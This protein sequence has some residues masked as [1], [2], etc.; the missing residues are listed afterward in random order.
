MARK[1]YENYYDDGTEL[2]EEDMEEFLYDIL[3]DSPEVFMVRTFEDEGLMTYNK[4][5]VVSMDDD[6]KS[7]FQITIVQSY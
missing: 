2:T 5:I 1:F 3:S 6:P 7:I 4:G